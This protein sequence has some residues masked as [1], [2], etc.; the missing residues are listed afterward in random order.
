M[1]CKETLATKGLAKEKKQNISLPNLLKEKCI[2][3]GIEMPVEFGE[4]KGNKVMT[5]RRDENDRY[6][7]TFG[8]GKARMIV[9]NFEEI[10][11]FAEEQ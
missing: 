6:P 3:G 8:K 5:I 7:F 1:L 11:K 2:Y 4:F 10:K 9:E